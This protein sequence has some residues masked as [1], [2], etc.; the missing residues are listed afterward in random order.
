MSWTSFESGKLQKLKYNSQDQSLEIVYRDGDKA[1]AEG[2]SSGRYEE[3]ISASVEDRDIFFT[4]L[5][6]PHV[7][8]RRS[9]RRMPSIPPGIIAL[10]LL[11]ICS[12]WLFFWFMDHLIFVMKR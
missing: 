9:V 2:I 12:S 7:T 1:R 5:I 4:N 11:V 8:W 3:L 6:E 10:A